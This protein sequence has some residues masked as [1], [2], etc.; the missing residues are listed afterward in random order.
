MRGLLFYPLFMDVDPDI[1]INK[2]C[3]EIIEGFRKIEQ[4]QLDI[5]RLSSKCCYFNDEVIAHFP[6]NRL[7]RWWFINT[8]LY[9]VIWRRIAKE[10]YSFGWI[11]APFLTSAFIRFLRRLKTSD[12]NVRIAL[13]YGSYPYFKECSGTKKVLYSC[14]VLNSPKL[15]STVDKI[16]TYCEQ[17]VIYRVP[18]IKLSNGIAVNPIPLTPSAP[19]SRRKLRFISVSGLFYWHGIDRFIRG[20][21][22]YQDHNP[23]YSVEFYI[24]GL[25]VEHDRLQELVNSLGLQDLVVFTGLK[26]GKD[27]D[28]LFQ[29]ADIGVGT[30]G[31][32][33]KNLTADSSLKNRE[34]A[35]RGLPF[36]LATADKDFP[37]D[38]PFVQYIPGDESAVD[39]QQV[40][41]FYERLRTLP[42]YAA[43]FRSYA[44]KNLDWS[45]KIHQVLDELFA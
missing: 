1:S 2:K 22:D 33:R 34:Y 15:R 23:V 16:I 27:L 35:A 25:G 30:L 44:E 8:T 20:M 6:A 7:K 31:M 10:T 9:E 12:Q 13:E 29:K 43:G 37:P 36:I 41:A 42:D 3:K 38:L 11:R 18:T 32:H 5:I 39:L 4:I 24:V 40:I 28:L 19:S 21:K 26:T 17:D 14:D 45:T